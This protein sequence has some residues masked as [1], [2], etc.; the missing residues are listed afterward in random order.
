MVALDLVT[1][2]LRNEYDAGYLLSC[3]GDLA[4]AVEEVGRLGKRVYAAATGLAA[5]LSKVA[6]R[7]IPLKAA[8]FSGCYR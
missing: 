6:F 5:A 2:A 8:W 4:P 7:T 3:D 1:M